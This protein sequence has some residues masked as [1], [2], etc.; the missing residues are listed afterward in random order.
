[1][2]QG[3]VSILDQE[4]CEKVESLW[5]ELEHEFG[6]KSA[7]AAYPHFSYQV[8]ERYDVQRVKDTLTRLT[9][10]AE[11]FNIRTS[12][13]GIFTGNGTTLY[14]PVARSVYLTKFHSRLWTRLS[15]T[16]RSI[17]THHYGPDNFIPHITL[18]A[19][20]LQSDQLPAII[21][22][23]SSRSFN[24]NIHIDNLALVLDA[25]GTR[26]QWIRY[27]LEGSPE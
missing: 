25:Q 9:I 16:A 4:H 11:P 1:M 17:H 5:D 27:P 3:V 7:A 8:V 18:A 23:L 26:D 15:K 2:L 24:W 21:K 19:G 10:T 13:L 6:L 20:D 14:I 12:G 22:L